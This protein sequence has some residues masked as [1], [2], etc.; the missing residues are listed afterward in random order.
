[1]IPIKNFETDGC[2]CKRDGCA[3]VMCAQHPLAVMEQTLPGMF[4]V[5]TERC[6]GIFSQIADDKTD[7]FFRY[8]MQK[9]FL[10]KKRL[11]IPT[12]LRELLKRK[13]VHDS[14]PISTV[15]AV[16]DTLEWPSDVFDERCKED[17]ADFRRQLLEHEGS[18]DRVSFERWGDK[19][20]NVG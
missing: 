6:G 14:M 8:W 12:Q 11:P 15:Q 4:G 20:H 13:G 17:L 19:M 1:M 10:E 18:A 5:P 7:V 16:L 3:E 2:Q 9:P